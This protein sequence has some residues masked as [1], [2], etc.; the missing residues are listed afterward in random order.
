[1]FFGLGFILV[2]F[3]SQV[4]ELSANYA[5]SAD[6]RSTNKFGSH[7]FEITETM[8][9]P[10]YVYYELSGFYQNHRRYEKSRDHLQMRDPEEWMKG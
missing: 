9:A 8:K 5:Q 10:V 1:M 4:V 7:I 6:E 2:N 3:A